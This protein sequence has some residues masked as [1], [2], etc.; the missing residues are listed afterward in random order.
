[1]DNLTDEQLDCLAMIAPLNQTE[2]GIK[3]ILEKP[4]DA[5]AL[6]NQVSLFLGWCQWCQRQECFIV[7]RPS[8]YSI[9]PFIRLRIY[10]FAHLS[11]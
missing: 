10:L 6:A 1:M 11:E 3:G 8:I 2:L 4:F 7:A 9:T 5:I